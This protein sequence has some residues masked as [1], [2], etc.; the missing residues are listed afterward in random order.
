MHCSYY[1][2]LQL[3]H[4]IYIHLALLTLKIYFF[5]KHINK[6]KYNLRNKLTTFTIKFINQGSLWKCH[7]QTVNFIN[8]QAVNT[9]QSHFLVINA[10]SW[11]L[12]FNMRDVEHFHPLACSHILKPFQTMHII[13]KDLCFG[14]ISISICSP[15]TFLFRST[16]LILLSTCT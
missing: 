8:I 3:C 14:D 9:R 13:K 16:A 4:L 15:F 10:S 11:W 7:M 5:I 6:M 12:C 1:I 2:A